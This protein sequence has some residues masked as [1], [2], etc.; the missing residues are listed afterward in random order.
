MKRERDLFD[1]MFGPLP[2]WAAWLAAICI[3]VVLV[4]KCL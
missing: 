4:A 3:I 2:P 1:E